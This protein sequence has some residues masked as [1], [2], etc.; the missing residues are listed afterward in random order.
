MRGSYRSASFTNILQHGGRLLQ[1]VVVPVALDSKPLSL[2]DGIPYRITRRLSV[3]TTIYFD[4]DALLET[5]K[6]EN[7]LLKG[8]LPPELILR[9][10][11]ITKQPPHRR[12]SGGRL[13]THVLCEM[14]DAFG[15]R[16]MAW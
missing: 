6:V 14:A 7:E 2:Q 11:S 15:Y 9:E 16:S 5:D 13:A 4:D 3:L 12:F 8:D 10:A 1:H